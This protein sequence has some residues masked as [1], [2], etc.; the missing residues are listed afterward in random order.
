MSRGTWEAQAEAEGAEKQTEAQRGEAV[1][2]PGVMAQPCP[3]TCALSAKL[4][5]EGTPERE[6]GQEIHQ[7][8]QIHRGLPPIS[9]GRRF[10]W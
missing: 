7:I 10:P 8:H 9:Q 1:G 2:R 4:L 6:I 5:G 3:G